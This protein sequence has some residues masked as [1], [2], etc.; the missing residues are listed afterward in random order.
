MIPMPAPNASIDQR[1]HVAPYFDYLDQ[2][3]AVVPLMMSLESHDDNAGANGIG[4][5]KKSFCLSF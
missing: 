3:N 1:N 2:A 4:M 5:T